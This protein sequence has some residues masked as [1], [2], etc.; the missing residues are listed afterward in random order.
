MLTDS[1]QI[2]DPKAHVSRPESPTTG[3]AISLGKAVGLFLQHSSPRI[4]LALSFCSI[5][6]R[7]SLGN[8]SAWD[9]VV[10]L[11]L[12][13]AWPI[14]EWL[15]HVF[16]LH[17]RPKRLLGKTLDLHAAQKHRRHHQHPLVIEWV[18]IPFRDLIGSS[19][20]IIILWSAVM[21]SWELAATGIAA[22]ITGALHY[23]WTHY[24]V[25]TTYLPV[26]PWGK[27]LRENHRLHHFRN[28]HHWYGVS[29]LAGDDFFGTGGEKHQVE[30]STTVKD[31]IGEEQASA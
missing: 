5:T 13:G 23:E 9:L 8:W 15:I 14:Q 31:I 11:L 20:L 10:V 12:I 3:Q 29:A 30:R 19:I 18:F 24:I 6:A 28:E 17:F 25:H 21:P 22:H 16:I 27:R 2:D 1:I 26:T 7:L 4:L